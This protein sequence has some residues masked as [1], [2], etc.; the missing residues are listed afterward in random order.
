MR[1]TSMSKQKSVKKVPAII[2]SATLPIWERKHF[3]SA[4]I[5]LFSFLLFAN[6]IQNDYNLDDELVTK[7]HRLTSKGFEAIPE[8]FTSPYYAD[9]MGYS[10]EYRPIVLLTFAIEHQI[11]GDSA[12]V[13]HFFNVLLYALACL[14]LLKTLQDLLRKYSQA[15]PFAITL[16]FAAHTAH[17]EV[18][19][20][21]KNRDEILAMI[22]GLLCLRASLRLISTGR[23]WILLLLPLFFTVALMSKTTIFSFALIIPIALLFFTEAGWGILISILLLLLLPS[24][25]LLN[26]VGGYEKFLL[27]LGFV[28]TISLL[29]LMKNIKLAPVKI[30]NMLR[31]LLDNFETKTSLSESDLPSSEG[32]MAIFKGVVPGKNI[33]FSVMAIPTLLIGCIYAFLIFRF[34]SP[35]AIVPLIALLIMAWFGKDG[36]SWWSNAVLSFC[37]AL[38]CVFL[39]HIDLFLA[40]YIQLSSLFF[41]ICLVF[42]RRNLFPPNLICFLIVSLFNKHLGSSLDNVAILGLV[43]LLNIKKLRPILVIACLLTIG[44]SYFVEGLVPNWT[45][46]SILLLILL[47][48]FAYRWIRELPWVFAISAL[49]I[50]HISMSGRSQD[51]IAQSRHSTVQTIS[52]IHTI[53]NQAN[54]QIFSQSQNRPLQY[55]EVCVSPFDSLTLRIGTSME[56]LSIYLQKVVLPYPLSYYYGYRF[57]KPQK[58]SDTIP[59]ISLILH[60]II[61]LTAI[62]TFFKDRLISFSLFSYL[63]LI[64]TFSNYYYYVPGMMA[65]R[66]LLLPSLSWCVFFVAIIRIF[67]GVYYYTPKIDWSEIKPIARYSFISVLLFYSALT[68]SRNANWRDDLTLFRHD[69][70]Y[71]SESSQANNLLALHLM[72]HTVIEPDPTAKVNMEN[73][74]LLHFKKALQI[75]PRFFNASYDI[76]RVYLSL[77][78]PDSALEAFKYALTID[79]VY[80]D[81]YKSIC[82]IYTFKKMYAETVPYLEHMISDNPLEYSAYGTLSYNF[83]LMKEY[84]KSIAVNKRAILAIPKIPDPYV[85]IYRVYSANNQM[86]SAKLYLTSAENLFPNNQEIHSLLQQLNNKP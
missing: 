23:K 75:Y 32:F 43:S 29:F 77:N 34:F 67:S 1:S 22:F 44:F 54:P 14:L 65:D 11:F 83:F 64:L 72:Q 5:F 19:S 36:L 12:H 78:Q 31:A 8:I 53:T 85:N 57:I 20:S 37:I 7:N 71:V 79:T 58:I 13:S 24:C 60:L 76:G 56:I 74:A 52:T 15:I 86:D 35:V 39:W 62:I 47:F 59:I 80:P 38:N 4:V 70:N 10:Y 26:T 2:S 82:D 33:F 21:I 17:T 50:F 9:N 6:S 46:G 45:D 68:F 25:F 61:L 66:F 3:L 16:L 18:V 51:F 55:I 42:G 69:I 84:Q 48:Q 28:S 41:S 73:E 81:L 30:G 27:V 63:I 49:L 40:E